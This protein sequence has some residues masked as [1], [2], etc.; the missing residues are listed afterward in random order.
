MFTRQLYRFSGPGS[1]RAVRIRYWPRLWSSQPGGQKGEKNGGLEEGE[2]KREQLLKEPVQVPGMPRNE[3]WLV[4]KAVASGLWLVSSTIGISTAVVKETVSTGS[5]LAAMG[6]R[7]VGSMAKSVLPGAVRKEQKVPSFVA[8]PVSIT[9]ASAKVGASAVKKAMSSLVG[10][11]AASGSAAAATVRQTGLIAEGPIPKEQAPTTETWK[12]LLGLGT[13]SFQAF[14]TTLDSIDQGTKAIHGA[15]VDLASD[16]VG[17]SFGQ[18]A[19]ELAKETIEATRDV[20]DAFK[21]VHT[22][23]AQKFSKRVAKAAGTAAAKTILVNPNEEEL[24]EAL[25]EAVENVAV[26]EEERQPQA[27]H[28]VPAVIEDQ[29]V[30]SI[31]AAAHSPKDLLHKSLPGPDK[32]IL[33]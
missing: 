29:R 2:E 3:P 10:L 32:P 33:E 1:V 8:V 11:G 14:T 17:H 13:T 26:I 12:A 5:A 27:E 16:V 9:A 21:A 25:E 31:A 4:D 20:M 18:E 15:S 7:E 30:D 19:G 22:F 6:I 23:N 28:F 24:S